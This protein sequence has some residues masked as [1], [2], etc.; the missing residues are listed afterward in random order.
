V[1]VAQVNSDE[2]LAGSQ[3]FAGAA[4]TGILGKAAQ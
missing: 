3:P 2:L 4:E 1:L